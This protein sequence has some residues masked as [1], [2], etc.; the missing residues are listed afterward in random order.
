MNSVVWLG[1]STR[2]LGSVVDDLSRFGRSNPGCPDHGKRNHGN[3]T[4]PA[5]YGPNKTRVLRGSTGES[6]FSEREGTPPF[7]ARLSAGEVVS[8]LAHVAEGVGTRKT[9]RAAT[10]FRYFGYNF[11]WPARSLRVKGDNGHGRARTPA[12]AAGLTDRVWSLNEWLTFS[13]VQRKRH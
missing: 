10:V 2:L 11:C 9:A 12:M 8:V 6:R 3:L 4:V 7:G 13:A 5:R 1:F